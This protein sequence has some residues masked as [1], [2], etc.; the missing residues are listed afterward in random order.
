L[1]KIKGCE[2]KVGNNELKEWMEKLGTLVSEIT[3]DRVNIGSN[4]EDISK[5]NVDD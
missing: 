2:F 3:K 5:N 4:E 1:I